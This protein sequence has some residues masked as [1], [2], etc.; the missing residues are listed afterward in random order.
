MQLL[1]ALTTGF[2]QITPNAAIQEQIPDK[3][4]IPL[5]VQLAPA[6]H[7][8]SESSLM[9]G[10]GIL[11]PPR[12]FVIRRILSSMLPLTRFPNHLYPSPASVFP[13]PRIVGDDTAHSVS[14]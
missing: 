12:A 10:L 6:P 4:V 1:T 11:H 8:H 7:N 14:P 9:G 13:C 3:L 2:I 5:S